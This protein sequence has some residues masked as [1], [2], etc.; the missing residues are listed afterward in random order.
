MS[1][2]PI[3]DTAASQNNTFLPKCLLF[4]AFPQLTRVYTAYRQREWW[5][6]SSGT[7]GLNV[8]CPITVSLLRIGSSPCW[9]WAVI[10]LTHVLGIS[11]WMTSLPLGSSIMIPCR[12]DN[13]WHHFKETV[14]SVTH[15]SSQNTSCLTLVSHH[16]HTSEAP[17]YNIPSLTRLF[18]KIPQKSSHFRQGAGPLAGCKSML[19]SVIK[20]ITCD[21]KEKKE[22][23]DTTGVFKRK[24]K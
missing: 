1:F 17:T 13:G 16:A 23:K 21:V 6:M 10:W 14:Q 12:W 5:K 8:P 11:L 24:H 2:I 4:P 20:T 7:T 9:M 3:N 15:S 22:I 19:S 18:L